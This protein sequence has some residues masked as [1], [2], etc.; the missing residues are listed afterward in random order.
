MDFV[1]VTEAVVLGA[2]FGMEGDYRITVARGALC[3]AVGFLGGDAA[4]GDA[5]LQE[6]F[7]LG[8]ALQLVEAEEVAVAACASLDAGVLGGEGADMPWLAAC[9]H[10]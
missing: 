6:F 10:P 3:L 2:A 5:L 1:E 9:Q 7:R 8:D 4:V